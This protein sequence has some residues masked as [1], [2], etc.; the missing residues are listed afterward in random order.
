M[1]STSA[2][3]ICGCAACIGIVLCKVVITLSAK[4]NNI[5]NQL[6]HPNETPTARMERQKQNFCSIKMQT[7][8]ASFGSTKRQRNNGGRRRRQMKEERRK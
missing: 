1:S 2:W 4:K 8:P 3:Y 5:I 7:G 6:C